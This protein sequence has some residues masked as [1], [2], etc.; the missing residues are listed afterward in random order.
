MRKATLHLVSCALAGPVKDNVGTRNNNILS[1]ETQIHL[2]LSAASSR[3]GGQEKRCGHC[4]T[5]FKKVH[6]SRPV[7]SDAAAASEAA[8]CSHPAV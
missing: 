2:Q 6:R 5:L 4:A 7:C 3:A 8:S 1:S